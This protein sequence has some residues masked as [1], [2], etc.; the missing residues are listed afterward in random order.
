MAILM[1]TLSCVGFTSCGS[2]DD[3]SP[4]NSSSLDYIQVR[5]YSEDVTAPNGN[6]YLFYVD[7][8]LD[9]IESMRPS[10]VLE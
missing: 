6:V 2:D 1:V 4:N 8:Y 7:N 10:T 5:V 3:D 9:K